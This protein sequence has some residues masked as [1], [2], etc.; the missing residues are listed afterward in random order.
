MRGGPGDRSFVAAHGTG[1]ERLERYVLGRDDG[2]PKS[3][4]WASVRCGVPATDIARFARAYAASSPAMLF[5]GFSI[6]RVFAGEEPSRLAV[7]LQVATG[8]FGVAGGSTGAPNHLLP[9]PRVGRLPVPP[10]APRPSIPSAR[11]ADA[12]REGRG[13]GYHTDIHALYALGSNVVNQGS[14]VTKSIAAFQKLDFAVTHS[15]FMTPTARLC[16]VVF[17]AASA[18]EKE[19]IGIPWVGNY[20]L[21]KPQVVPPRGQARNDYDALCD[22]ADRMGFHAEFSEGRSAAQWIQHFIEGSEI[23]DPAEFRRSGFYAAADQ[24]RVGLSDFTRDPTSH[25]LGTPSGKVEIASERYFAETGF[26]A[27]PS[28]QEPPRCDV[29]PLR[30]I[31]PKSPHFTHSQ[32]WN[33][34]AVRGRADH[35][36]EMHTTDA[37]DRGLAEGDMVSV[38]NAAGRCGWPCTFP[39]TLLPAWSP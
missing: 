15:I 12:I 8:N 37:A 6:Q 35:F 18:F 36:L 30:L 3:P 2:V 10:D 22:L 29:R 38:F 4:D 28:W 20:L 33:I 5:P 11:L 7:A 13:G 25:P 9:A 27:V 24:E 34:P 14:D 26:S 17:P 31:T 19:D 16:D 23:P 32:G 21:Y 1:F 39:M